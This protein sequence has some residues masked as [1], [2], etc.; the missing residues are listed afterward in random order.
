MRP[1]EMYYGDGTITGNVGCRT[2]TLIIESLSDCDIPV[3]S[4]DHFFEVNKWPWFDR[5]HAF[6]MHLNIP[7]GTTIRFESGEQRQ[8]RLV[9]FG[10]AKCL[11]GFAGLTRGHRASWILAR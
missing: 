4:H 10:G 1:D 8:V 3:T 11:I 5:A 9:E 2:V 6:G 7:P